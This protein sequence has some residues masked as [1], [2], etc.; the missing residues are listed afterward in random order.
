MA[1]LGQSHPVITAPVP[2]TLGQSWVDRL[3]R[4]ES[5]AFTQRRARRTERSGANH[6]PIVWEAAVGANVIDVDGNVYVDLTSGFGVAAIGHRHPAVVAAIEHQSKRLVHGLGDLHPSQPKIEL[7]ERLVRLSPWDDARA[8]LSLSGADAVTTALKTAVLASKRPGVLAFTGSY[9]GLGYGPLAASAFA[10][11][12][13]EP[14]REQLNPHVVFAPWPKH[15]WKVEDALRELPHDWSAIGAVLIEPIQG[16]GGV[17]IPPEGF[18]AAL[19]D[20]CK[21]EGALLVV[22][23]IFTGFGRCG[24]WWCSQDQGVSP[25]LI[26]AGKALGGGLPVSVCLGTTEV[27]SSWGAPG[28]EAIHTGTFF[29][30]PLCAAAALAT[31]DV[32]ENTQLISGGRKKGEDW[33]RS[34]RN[35][36]LPYVR[37]VRGAGMMVGLELD[38]GP[39]ALRVARALLQRGYLVLCAGRDGRVLQLA[40]PLNIDEALLERFV[41][42]LSQVLRD[43][44]P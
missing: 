6:D 1:E 38:Q 16:R 10:P 31:L 27:M 12:F 3:A 19:G 37:E 15:T 28:E 4:A 33:M 40:P 13:R 32:L 42:A 26:C 35:A 25:D 43:E 24:S 30:H 17:N 14:F 5:P 21:R 22:D 41:T 18:L 8:V 44:R 36:D 23:E 34:L 20:R 7:L 11:G 29:G 9:H 39:R 2:T